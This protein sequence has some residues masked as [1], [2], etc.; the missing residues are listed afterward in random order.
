MLVVCIRRIF[1]QSW[2][3]ISKANGSI[4]LVDVVHLSDAAGN[5]LATK[6]WEFLLTK[7][8]SD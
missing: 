8:K 6:V 1:G 4:F 3:A 5:I 7:C 2:D